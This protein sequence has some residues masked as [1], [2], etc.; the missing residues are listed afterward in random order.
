MSKYDHQMRQGG[1]TTLRRKLIEENVISKEEIPLRS[2]MW[3]KGRE[4]KGE[5]KDED[6]EIMADKLM[7][8]KKQIKEGQV[9]VEPGTDAMTLVFGKENGGFL[10]GV[11]T[12]VTYNR[13]F[14]VPRS[15]GSS[16]EEIKDLKV[17]LHNGKLKLE[18]KDVE[19][20]ALSTKVNE[21][22]QTLKLVLAHLNAKGADFPNLSHTIGISSE[23]IVQSNETSPVSLKNNEPSELV[24]PVIPKP[25]KKTVQTKSA[26]AA[27][28][29]KLISMKSATA[30]TKTTNKTVESKTTNI[31]QNIP[32]VSSNNPIHQPIKCSL[33]YPYKRNIVAHGT[34][35]LSSEREFIHGVPLQDDC[36]KVS[37][38]EVVVKTA[39]LPHQTGEFKLVEDA[40]KSFVPWPKYFVHTESEVPEIIS[41]QKSTKRK[42]T[43]I[44]SNALT[45]KTRSNTN[46]N[47]A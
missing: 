5:F 19:L 45:K 21:Q 24:T 12:V 17:A 43:Y 39:F 13:Y 6:V 37:I 26:T 46:K 1:Y 27:P 33:S 15:K 23:K 34:I 9:N 41:H 28:D 11:G 16:K 10:K 38:D 22:D 35:H 32:K 14:N 36:Y 30:N 47:N 20:K 3:S 44:S 18:K 8:H 40:Y 2:V 4:S 31:N 25:N 7:E 29:A 42:P